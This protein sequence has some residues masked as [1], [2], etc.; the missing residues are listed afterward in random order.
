M[1]PPRKA[2]TLTSVPVNIFFK[3]NVIDFEVKEY[4][5][6]SDPSYNCLFKFS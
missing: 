4:S 5:K 1:G 3:L 2:A 6:E